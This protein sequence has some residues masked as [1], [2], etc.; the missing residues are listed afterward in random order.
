MERIVDLKC[1]VNIAL[2]WVVAARNSW[3]N[4]NGFS[5]NQLV[6]GYNSVVLD[7]ISA[8]PSTLQK[9]TNAEMVAASINAMHSARREF[10]KNESNEKIRRALLNQV[11]PNKEDNAN[12]DM[13]ILRESIRGAGKEQVLLWR[14]TVSRPWSNTVVLI[15]EFPS[16]DC[17]E[18]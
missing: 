7:V 6:F 16:A 12:G 14:E 8:S 1:L 10:V 15:F 2:S 18:D 3:H 11:R 9:R 13:C 5:P 4:C 17:K